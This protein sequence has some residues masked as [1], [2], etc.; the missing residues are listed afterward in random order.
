MSTDR[1][2]RIA[3]NGFGRIGRLAARRVLGDPNMELVAINDLA[4]NASLTYLFQ[5][6]SVQGPYNG[7][8]ALDG[9]TLHVDGQA[10]P[11]TEN[12]DILAN[13]WGELGV[14]VVL[15]CTGV[16]TNRAGNAPHFEAGAKRVIISAP[17]KD[18]DVTIVLG[19]NEDQF[20][21]AVRAAVWADMLRSDPVGAS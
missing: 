17:A 5:R 19:V 6:D 7:E 12:R 13:K 21:P 10:V 18:P 9:D 14:D 8:V 3:I 15:E 20:D 2:A 1:K 16:F 4:D 11:M